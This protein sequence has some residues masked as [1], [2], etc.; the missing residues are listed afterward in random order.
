MKE[1]E[2]FMEQV[3]WWEKNENMIPNN[4]VYEVGLIVFNV[5][6]ALLKEVSNYLLFDEKTFS[7]SLHLSKINVLKARFP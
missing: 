3:I 4:R 7:N 6:K 2:V 1:K 5:L